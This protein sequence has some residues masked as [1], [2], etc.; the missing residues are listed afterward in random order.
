MYLS[1]AGTTPDEP[2]TSN[3]TGTPCPYESSP[4]NATLCGLLEEIDDAYNR[5]GTTAGTT[6]G[7][8]PFLC[9]YYELDDGECACYLWC[10][11]EELISYRA[12]IGL[13]VPKPSP[14]T[15][16]VCFPL[17][18]T[19]TT[20]TVTSTTPTTCATTTVSPCPETE[21]VCNCNINF[22]TPPP[23][24]DCSTSTTSTTTTTT[25]TIATTT[26]TTN[27]SKTTKAYIA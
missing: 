26:T 10:K 3:T 17:E 1:G 27:M 8:Q 18:S 7:I 6:V 2:L 21:C 5:P 15:G 19:S 24:Q 9:P 4:D 14:I 23:A 11:K 25:T 13:E 22:G 16:T 12:C 20:E